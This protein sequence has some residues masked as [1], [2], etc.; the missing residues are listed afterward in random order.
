MNATL[1]YTTIII[2]LIMVIFYSPLFKAENYRPRRIR[3]DVAFDNR[4]RDFHMVETPHSSGDFKPWTD[5]YWMADR[6]D[7]P[8]FKRRANLS[9]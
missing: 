6:D 3:S 1:I 7:K 2:I 8:G 5:I 4:K 9:Y